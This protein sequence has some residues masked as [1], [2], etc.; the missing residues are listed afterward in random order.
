MG[1]LWDFYGIS[2]GFLL[3]FYGISMGFLWDFYGI[4]M[5][6]YGYSVTFFG[7]SSQGTIRR[8]GEIAKCGDF[9]PASC[10]KIRHTVYQI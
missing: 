5:V 9:V 4:S 7:R 2:M 8:F 3:D 1:F 6:T 10:N